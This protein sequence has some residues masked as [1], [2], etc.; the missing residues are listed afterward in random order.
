MSLWSLDLPRNTFTLVD[1]IGPLNPYDQDWYDKKPMSSC[2]RGHIF[3]YNAQ[4]GFLLLIDK[5]QTKLI[6]HISLLQFP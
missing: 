2:N 4:N 3:P 5:K 1:N 6:Y